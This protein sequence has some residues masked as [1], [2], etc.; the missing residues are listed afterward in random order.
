MQQLISVMIVDDEIMALNNEKNLIDW[1]EA[2][3]TIVASETNPRNA[4]ESFHKYR[5]Q[6]AL[7]DIMMPVMNG[8]ELSREIFAL[9][10]PVKI[11]ILTSYKDFQYAKQSVGIGVSNYLVKHEINAES[12]IAELVKI[13]NEIQ[14]TEKNDRYLRQRLIRH[15]IG[16]LIPYEKIDLQI[17]NNYLDF[18]IDKIAF[19]FTKIDIPYSILNEINIT[20]NIHN[21]F[22]WDIADIV[23]EFTD[24]EAISLNSEEALY[25]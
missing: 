1:E 12:L 18:E 13:K 24:I 22:I 21:K 7:V 10:I 9:N 4:L 5:P 8:L 3:Y 11:I 17:T 15:L 23:D 19:L 2:G 25:L 16:G 14:N 20:V 6:I